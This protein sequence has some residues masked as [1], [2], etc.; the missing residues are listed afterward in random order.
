MRVRAEGGFHQIS[1]H[2]LG[3]SPSTLRVPTRIPRGS[4]A[5][6]TSMSPTTRLGRMGWMAIPMSNSTHR[7]PGVHSP[8]QLCSPS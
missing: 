3:S 4:Q 1:T 5:H 2:R 6:A 8:V 7:D